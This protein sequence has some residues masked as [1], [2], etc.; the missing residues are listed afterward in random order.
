LTGNTGG[1]RLGCGGVQRRWVLLAAAA[2][3]AAVLAYVVWPRGDRPSPPTAVPVA[4]RAA[5]W[6]APDAPIGSGGVDGMVVDERGAPIAGAAVRAATASRLAGDGVGDGAPIVTTGADGRYAF[7][8]ASGPWILV[9][10]AAGR[11]PAE[12]TAEV[13]LGGRVRVDLTLAAGGAALRGQVVDATGGTIT[14]ASIVLA[15]ELGVL[16]AEPR[17]AAAATSGGDGRF[18]VGVIPG[19]WRVTTSHPDYVADHRHID[20]GPG[21]ATVE[22]PLVPGGVIEGTVRDRATR[23]PVPGARVRYAREVI[24]RGP[25][26]GAAAQ[27][28]AGGAVTAGA[29]GSFRITGLGAGRIVIDA[30]ADDRVTD[31]PTEVQLGIAE[32]AGDVDVLVAP[33]PSIS[34]RVVYDDGSPAP[35]AAVT[36]ESRGQL[37]RAISHDHGE[38]RIPG[39]RA[40]RHVLVAEADDTLPSEPVAVTVAARPVAGVELTVSR[41]AFV[42]GRVDPPGP[43]A[44]TVAPADADALAMTPG[45]MAR[46]TRA[47]TARADRD[48]RFR[49][50][51]FAPGTIVLMGRAPDGRRGRAAVEVAAAGTDGVVVALAERG[52]IGGRVVSRAGAPV[53][54]AVVS[55][56][57]AARERRTTIVNGVD[58]GA[59]RAPVDADGRFAIA[60]LDAGTWELTVLDELGAP[61]AFDRPRDRDAPERVELADGQTREGIALV[62]EVK[63]GVIEGVVLDPSGAPVPDAWVSVSSEDALV[64][65]IGRIDGGGRDGGGP[66]APPP[67]V[68]GDPQ[69]EEQIVV[70]EM[71]SDG[72]GRRAGEIPPILTGPDGRFTVSSLRRGNYRVAAEGLRG[73]A[74]GAVAGVATGS[75]VTVRLLTLS[76]LRGTVAI[77]GSPVADFT[78]A[79]HGPSQKRREIHDDRGEFVVTGL[80]P[81]TY[82]IEARSAVGTGR[83][84]A[85]VAAGQDTAVMIEL[86]APGRV[87]GTVVDDT[88]APIPD[89]MVVVAPRQSAGPMR[90][91]LDGAPP[92]TSGDGGFEVSAEAGARTLVV[93]GPRGPDVQRDLDVRAGETID[94]GT[95]TVAARP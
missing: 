95:I 32:T 36:V 18:D 17:R 3:L 5:T 28:R 22:I 90:L 26:G 58:I 25:I 27:R 14:G 37:L 8:L 66:P 94:L 67:S 33:A 13:A 77:G 86:Q 64:P 93:L 73:G 50:G 51:P 2:A 55:L 91:E 76:R 60:G 21:G 75:D 9:A 80:D 87:V 61:L 47:P 57:R 59:D 83:V 74:R 44:I 31:E 92:R 78:I 82:T 20:V 45:R 68:A 72:D 15:P 69:R 88:G 6:G 43:A 54:G 7:D 19:R 81:G 40:G 30:D 79:A 62:V 38:F 49:I 71:I 48:G 39:V 63:D 35:G 46:R 16:G 10:S 70:A 1:E 41:G 56:R 34:G 23:A 89:R 11:V 29:D 52:R 85:E 42:T 24:A 12:A 84:A 4:G 65:G 53:P